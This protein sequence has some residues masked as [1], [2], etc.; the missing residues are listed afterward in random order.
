M[1]TSSAMAASIRTEDEGTVSVGA[2]LDEVGAGSKGA[3]AS[4]GVEVGAGTASAS[5]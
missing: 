3:M 2:A 4:V 5:F 1:R